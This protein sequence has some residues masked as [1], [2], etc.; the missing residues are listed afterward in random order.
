[1]DRLPDWVRDPLLASLAG[2]LEAEE[3]WR[4]LRVVLESF[5]REVSQADRELGER[6]SGELE[7]LGVMPRSG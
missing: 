1:M 2:R 4:A 3:L 5:A 6:V 7:G